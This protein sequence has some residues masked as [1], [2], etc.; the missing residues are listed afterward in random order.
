[1]PG[2]R[3][4]LVALPLVPLLPAGVLAQA[5]AHDARG[6]SRRD[7]IAAMATALVTHVTPALA[8]RARTEAL[9]TQPMLM[10]RGAR[11]SG[12]L[13][14]AVMLNGE[15]W[16]MPGGEPVA[17]IW[18]EG[19]IDRRHPHT[20]LH[21]VMLTGVRRLGRWRGSLSAGKGIVPFGTDDPMVRPFTKYPANHHFSQVLERVQ[22]VAGLRP[23]P[24]LAFELAVFNG[25]EP[26]SPL[27]APRWSRVGDSRA[28]RLTVWAR[29]QLELQGSA[30]FVR[31][32]EFPDGAGLDQQKQSASARWTPSGAG[33]LRYLLVE[34]A[35]TAERYRSRPIV[36]YG[37]GLAEAGASQWA[38]GGLAPARAD[39]ATRGRAPARP[40]PHQPASHRADGARGD[41]MAAGHGPRRHVAAGAGWGP[42]HVVR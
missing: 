28:G 17:A 34:W 39:V 3:C 25:D 15:R 14:Y 24:R 21:E 38:M 2:R 10:V 1:M 33:A 9:V 29:P 31:S 8:G 7:S 32:P 18:G 41:P 6:A 42:W 20:V 30:A 11:A 4:L 16:T 35:R 23:S 5:H 36:A 19:F 22:L 13:Q 12:A 26:T 37:S 40:V 27:A